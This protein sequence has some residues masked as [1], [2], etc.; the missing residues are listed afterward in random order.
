MKEQLKAFLALEGYTIVTSNLPEFLVFLKKEYR[1][2]SV[3][4]VIELESGSTFT[5]ERYR[6]VYDSACKLLEKNDVKEMHILTLIISDNPEHAS[7]VCEEDKYAWVINRRDKILVI[8][9]N[10]IEDFY[11][12]KASLE[13]FLREPEAASRQIRNVEEQVL[14]ELK[15]KEKELFKSIYIPWV[16]YV[17]VAINI[18][19]YIVCTSTGELLYN[20][21][22]MTVDGILG[23]GQWYRMLTGMFLH[24][25]MTHLFNNMLM[26]YLLGNMIEQRLGRWGFGVSYF[27]CG[28]ASGFIS[29]VSKYFSGMDANSIGASGAVYGIFGL[30]LIMEIT[31]INWR[32]V[33]VF[34]IRRMIL[35]VLCVAV[36]LYVDAQIAGVDFKAHVGG[37]CMGAILGSVWYLIQVGKK[38]KKGHEN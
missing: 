20:T 31:T 22:G 21:G 35:V 13:M 9:E 17:L 2:V 5:K 18:V 11:G 23:D 34:T 24:G 19:V 37:L 7:E 26:L 32:R 16:T 6:S 15:K 33:S 8:D 4:F 36:S 3:I 10:K 14:T 27:V 1:H 38:R 25:E 28:I 12:M 29:L 30:A